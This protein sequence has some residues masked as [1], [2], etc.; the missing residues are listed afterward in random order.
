MGLGIVV[1]VIITKAIAV[2]KFLKRNV[3]TTQ[4]KVSGNSKLIGQNI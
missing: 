4:L 2:A 3:Q 1:G